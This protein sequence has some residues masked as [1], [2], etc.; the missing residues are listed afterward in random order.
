MIHLAPSSHLM[1]MLD[2]ADPST[3]VPRTQL[4]ATSV[5]S[6]QSFQTAIEQPS[7]PQHHGGAGSGTPKKSQPQHDQP[8]VAGK[9]KPK[10][11]A[12]PT[13]TLSMNAM[14][15]LNKSKRRE[16]GLRNEINILEARLSES[17]AEK[18]DA[19][20]AARFLE[21]K[22]TESRK[23][24]ETMRLEM[25]ELRT[26]PTHED[27]ER[28]AAKLKEAE[29]KVALLELQVRTTTDQTE[30]SVIAAFVRQ[31]S[32][33]QTK[34]K[35]KE[36]YVRQLEHENQVSRLDA[37]DAE[38]RLAELAK[39]NDKLINDVAEGNVQEIKKA[40]D[41]LEL[42]A[43]EQ[44]ATI[45]KLQK[46]SDDFYRL[47]KAEIRK[48]AC[49]RQECMADGHLDL[50]LYPRIAKEENENDVTLI[51]EKRRS[52]VQERMSSAENDA[53]IEAFSDP[54]QYI[55]KLQREI[56]YHIRDVVAFRLDI[57]GY[58]KDVNRFERQIKK[59][60]TMISLLQQATSSPK[61]FV[62]AKTVA[63]NGSR[64][65]CASGTTFSS[66]LGISPTS[67]SPY[68]ITTKTTTPEPSSKSYASVMPELGLILKKDVELQSQASTSTLRTNKDLPDPPPRSPPPRPTTPISNGSGAEFVFST[69]SKRRGIFPATPSSSLGAL[70]STTSL[71]STASTVADP[72]TPEATPG[73]K[74]KPKLRSQRSV[75]ESIISSYAHNRWTPDVTPE[76]RPFSRASSRASS[77]TGNVVGTT[78]DGSPARPTG[79]IFGSPMA[80]SGTVIHRP[81]TAMGMRMRANT[82]ASLYSSSDKSSFRA[83]VLADAESHQ[84]KRSQSDSRTVLPGLPGKKVSPRAN[85]FSP[86]PTTGT[87]RLQFIPNGK[88]DLP[89]TRRAMSPASHVTSI[90]PIP[91]ITINGTNTV[92]VNGSVVMPSAS[93]PSSSDA[94]TKKTP[95]GRFRRTPG[96][97]PK[98]PPPISNV[99]AIQAIREA[100]G[101]TTN[102]VRLAQQRMDESKGK[103]RKEDIGKNMI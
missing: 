86:A 100:Q 2:T 10:S 61:S 38:R 17:N 25:N 19:L 15:Q 36:A 1:L 67:N 35:E 93:V 46:Q 37:D 101:K 27:V 71:A 97:G 81:G 40:N 44:Q 14:E 6:L 75:S 48:K 26:R 80:S 65:S 9:H 32:D 30:A 52:E 82:A 54:Q 11:E 41:E 39:I 83:N 95:L 5:T 62:S 87:T 59:R 21:E 18:V 50:E 53:A 12:E 70:R 13:K 76:R 7:G 23:R 103:F 68:S 69:P 3:P 47:L 79:G 88:G 28:M 56:D 96:E 85:S 77:R 20:E 102:Y 51:I 74:D 49:K 42:K 78:P 43:A 8:D 29:N 89:E 55:Q 90:S 92:P 72:L 94:A 31:I 91:N 58:K 16:R 57:K 84:H 99:K 22:L 60:D 64:E 24:D 34:L 33:N 98:S 63:S 45:A 66:G 4:E 73:S